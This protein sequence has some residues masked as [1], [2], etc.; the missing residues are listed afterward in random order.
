M[1]V[2]VNTIKIVEAL[3]TDVYRGDKGKDY[4]S[5]VQPGNRNFK[6]GMP[7]EMVKD[8]EYGNKISFDAEVEI[9]TGKDGMYM[10]LENVRL[11][12]PAKSV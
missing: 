10:Q 3:V 7:S 1:T 12:K 11:H 2:T 4:I 8:V 6:L 5:F 9:K